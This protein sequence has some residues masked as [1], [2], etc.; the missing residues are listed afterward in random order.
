MK[1]IVEP[2]PC[3]KP[4]DTILIKLGLPRGEAGNELRDG[5]TNNICRIPLK[6][7]VN[8]FLMQMAIEFSYRHEVF[9]NQFQ[10]FRDRAGHQYISK[11]LR[12][13]ATNQRTS[14]IA[15]AVPCI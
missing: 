11:L 1:I 8:A 12:I 4:F 7:P 2:P 5:W 9:E 13:W 15:L 3:R 10:V 6:I 14:C